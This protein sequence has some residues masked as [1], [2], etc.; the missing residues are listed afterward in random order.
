[1]CLTQ[2]TTVPASTHHWACLNPPQCLPQPT[3]VPASTHHCACLNP[4]LCLPPKTHHCACP[5]TPT[6]ELYLESSSWY[7]LSLNSIWEEKYHEATVNFV[8]AQPCPEG[9]CCLSQLLKD[10]QVGYNAQHYHNLTYS[11]HKTHIFSIIAK[12]SKVSAIFSIL[13]KK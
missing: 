1:M 10:V 11:L 13:T 3:T 2:P 7:K 8:G 9:W 12:K 5:Q 4:P 6:I